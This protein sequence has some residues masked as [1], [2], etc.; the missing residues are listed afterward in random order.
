MHLRQELEQRGFLYQYTN[1]AVFELFDKWGKNL[2][3]GVDPTADSLHLGNFVVFMHAV[4][5]MKR[6]NRLVL[7]VGGATG[8]IGDPGGKDV[9]RS[10][11][12]EERLESNVGAIT[13]QVRGILENLQNLSG[14]DFSFEV[15]NNKDFYVQMSYLQFLRDVGKYITVN[16][17]INKETVKKRIEDPDKFISY[18]EFSYMLL[19]GYDFYRL[20]KDKKVELQIASSD[21]WGN[22]VTG[23]ELIRKK[24]NAEVYGVTWPLV[25]DAN[26]KKFGK[27]E[28]NAIWL[29]PRKSTP[30]M[31]YQYFMNTADADVERFL[32]FFTLLS[33]DQIQAIVDQH[34][35]DVSVRYGQEQLAKYV[36]TTV[37]GSDSSEDAQR[38]TDILFGQWDKMELLQKS[39]SW[40]LQALYLAIWG[41]EVSGEQRI[42]DL[43]VQS[44]LASSNGEAKK[45]IASKSVYVNE[46][47]LE[48]IQKVLLPVDAIHWILLLRK[49]KKQYKIVRF[50]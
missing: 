28:G 36:V 18:T 16:S 38:V 34:M 50:V 15:V 39:S 40:T 45:L 1:E 31:V 47:L 35:Q 44:G 49:G 8:M 4:N 6:G 13:E 12:D 32:K 25:L 10:F 43:C 23:V 33:L 3:F 27:S 5:Y 42:V 22:I 17:M 11:L 7:V 46:S 2:Y 21:Q 24:D 14:Y 29:D 30:Y 48:D 26:G 20:Y 37:F 9:E 19:Q 41:C